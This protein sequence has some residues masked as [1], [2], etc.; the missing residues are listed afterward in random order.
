MATLATN[1]YKQ[2]GF[3]IIELVIVILVIGI[4]SAVALPRM[5]DLSSQARKSVILAITGNLSTSVELL[6]SQWI[7]EGKNPTVTNFDG[8]IFYIGP[9]N[10]NN[11]K[12]AV[13]NIG[14]TKVDQLA[15]SDCVDLCEK[16]LR[17]P[18]KALA[19]S[20]CL[21]QRTCKFEVTLTGNICKYK[22]RDDNFITYD[23]ISGFVES[24][25]GTGT[26]EGQSS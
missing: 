4:L 7:A 19:D 1:K 24:T 3:T 6:R 18:P 15:P 10:E 8:Q 17:N 5:I 13:Q 14:D 25:A 9:K 21:I 16:L 11:G 2:G 26:L 12:G 22:D 20:N 23:R